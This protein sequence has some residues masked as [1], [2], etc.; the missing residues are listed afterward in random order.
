MLSKQHERDSASRT[1][2]CDSQIHTQD[3]IHPSLPNCLLTSS[4]FMSPKW[5]LFHDFTL[6]QCGVPQ[7]D[8]VRAT[9]AKAADP[10]HFFHDSRAWFYSPHRELYRIMRCNRNRLNTCAAAMLR[11]DINK[12][13]LQREGRTPL[14]L[15]GRRTQTNL[16]TIIIAKVLCINEK[17]GYV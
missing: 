3:T 11:P 6:S 15:P 8:S 13:P 1:S 10:S 14:P 2:W 12:W 17:A 9:L 4:A 7:S 16:K 5:R